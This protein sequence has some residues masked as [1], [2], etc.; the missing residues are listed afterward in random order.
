[1]TSETEQQPLFD[2]LNQEYL[3]KCI[4][5][6]K[7]RGSQYGDTLRNSQWLISKSIFRMEPGENITPEM[8]AMAAMCDIKYARFEGG[9]KSDTVL[10]L[11]NYLSVLAGLI[12]KECVA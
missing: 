4:A 1:M 6:A 8:V 11:I 7:E 5:L 9:Y 2:R 10:D 12:E 3:E